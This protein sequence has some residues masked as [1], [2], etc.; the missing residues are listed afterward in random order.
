MNKNLILIILLSIT[1]ITNENYKGTFNSSIGSINTF[2][3]DNKKLPFNPKEFECPQLINPKNIKLIKNINITIQIEYEKYIH[4]KITDAENKKRWT[5]PEKETLNPSYIFNRI[6]NINNSSSKF[7]INFP[8]NNSLSF[9]ILSLNNEE[10]YSFSENNFL[11]SETLIQFESFLTSNDIYGFGEHYHNLKLEDGIYTIWPNDTGGIKED[12]RKGGNNLMGHQ[13]IGIHKTKYKN[14]FLGFVFINSNMQDLIIKTISDNKTSLIHKTIGGIIDYYI[15]Y[16]ESPDEINRNINF[17]LGIPTLPPFWSM[18][19][20]QSRYGYKDSNEFKNVYLKYKNN[21]IPIDTLWIDI[22]SLNNFE[23]FTLDKNKF[24][25]LLK[26]INELHNEKYHFVPIVDLGISYENKRNPF[27]EIGDKL[28]IFIKSNY[29]KKTLISNVWPGDT[30]FPDFFNPNTILV[31]H[32]GLYSYHKL[33]NYDGIWLDMNEPAMLKRDHICKGE[34]ANKCN[35][36]DNYYY[37]EDL[38]YIPGYKKNEHDDIATGSINENA[39]NYGNDELIYAS[40]N[41]KPLI[42]LL[43]CKATYNFLKYKLNIRPFVL[44]R[45]TFIGCGKY[46][47]H[48]LGD[49]KS[50]YNDMKNSING[51]FQFNIFGIPMTGDDICGFM[52]NS[53]ENLCMR[54]H[55]LGVFYP[56]SRNHN[57]IH[58][59]DQFP[60]SFSQNAMNVI[61]NAINYK[62]SLLRYFYSEMVFI[63]LNEKSSLFK[64]VFYTFPYDDLSYFDIDERVMIGDCFIL[65]PIFS[66]NIDNVEKSFPNGNWNLYP[67]GE[68]IIKENDNE[69]KKNI[70][71]KFEDINIYLRGGCVVPFQDIFSKFIKNSYHLRQENMDLIINLNTNGTGKGEFFYDNDDV[72]TIEKKNYWRIN[73]SYSN[74][75]LSINTNKNNLNKYLYKDNILGK[76]VILNIENPNLKNITAKTITKNEKSNE[77]KGEYVLKFKKLIFNFSNKKIKLE[78]LK[79]I[80][81]NY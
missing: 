14:I 39:I 43:Q 44:T 79:Q 51:I 56:F 21:K 77:I 18:G 69:R 61:K 80:L 22:D 64:P 48:W 78:E 52:E 65:F 17:L 27:I 13:P 4:L 49:N 57:F 33:V 41:T 19:F 3:Y 54:W 68:S 81:F 72:D 37:Y 20:H 10:L 7:K 9:K 31:W 5:V 76:I 42:S 53:Y 15:I 2:S 40:Y 6:S 11:F 16:G 35:K 32:Y 36:E 30:V 1:I 38:P 46:S 58:S 29:T 50:D 12:D 59:Q 55:N 8:S 28:D 73:L 45:A 75:I 34:I 24:G 62:Y 66:D 23:I 47:Y 70:S 71:G 74:K 25:N 63:G 67:S 26:I 60:W